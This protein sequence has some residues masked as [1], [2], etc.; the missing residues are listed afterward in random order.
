MVAR[1]YDNVEWSGIGDGRK[2]KFSY[3]TASIRLTRGVKLWPAY[4][5][6]DEKR[7]NTISNQN[8]FENKESARN[9]TVNAEKYRRDSPVSFNKAKFCLSS[10]RL[11]FTIV[12]EPAQPLEKLYL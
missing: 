2:E 3:S 1:K 7:R 10:F 11:K 12:K 6:N 9:E 8:K 4:Y 5:G